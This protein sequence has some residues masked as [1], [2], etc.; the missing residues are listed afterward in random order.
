RW[1][2]GA[3]DSCQLPFDISGKDS[4]SPIIRLNE[5]CQS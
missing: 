5:T 2:E 4:N 3:N 1:G